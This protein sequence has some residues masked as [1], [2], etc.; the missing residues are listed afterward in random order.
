MPIL[1]PLPT[2]A[3]NHQ[4]FNAKEFT[5]TGGGIVVEQ[6][7]FNAKLLSENLS[8]L[9]ANPEALIKMSDKVKKL[10]IVDAAK[11]LADE[12]EKFCK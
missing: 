9:M 2:A 4:Y 8:K 3:D 5:E 1:I 11:R 10:A 7:D 6:K 12:V